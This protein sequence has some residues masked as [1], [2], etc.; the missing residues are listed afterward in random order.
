M[1][2]LLERLG[3]F[4]PA[5][6]ALALPIVFLPS[7]S[8]S[9]ILPRASI[10]ITAACLGSGLAL[11]APAR[12]GLGA[13]KWP[14]L[15]A[16]AAAL[17]AFAFS[18][19]WPLSLAGSYTRY[20]SLPVRLG[21]LGLFASTVWLLRSQKARDLVIPA[22]VLGTAIACLEAI[23]QWAGQV[24]FRPDGNLG[25]A[26]L[27]AALIA[28][29]TPLAVF[30]GLTRSRF[31]VAW[32]AAAVLMVAGL[33]VTTSRSGA[34]GAIAGCLLLIVLAVRGRLAGPALAAS[35]AVLGA[36]VLVILFSPVNEL[37]GDPAALRLNLWR[38]AVRM[39]AARPFTGWGEDTTGLVFGGFLSQNYAAQVTFDRIHSG[40]LDIAATQGLLGLGALGWVVV[41]VLRSAWLHR[42]DRSVGALFA[43]LG[44]YAV[45]VLLN[46][47]WAP[48][49]GLFWLLA[50]TLWSATTVVPP[51][52]VPAPPHRWGG[53]MKPLGAAALV[54]VA[55]LLAVFP[56][57][58]DTWYLRGRAD[59]SVA[60]DPLQARYHWAWG[61]GLVARGELAAGVDELKRAAG[62]GETEPALYVELGDREIEM[63]R[64]TEAVSAYRQA[65]Q[66][67][68]YYEPALQR[69]GSA[70]S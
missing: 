50:G 15:A 47:D 49:A 24:P 16:A 2:Y 35:A 41:T 38:D 26:N 8:D 11:M 52:A 70:G 69:L 63:G 9:Y 58:A 62:L 65:L 64:R 53:V 13:I 44:G 23:Q 33:V 34:L 40:P 1:R 29:G 27:L 68:P 42:S 43:A 59:L 10:V 6:I 30:N 31:M 60:V 12:P 28:M 19:S 7:V 46:F 67:D 48:A 54:L 5:L 57:L 17:L 45:W 36:V 51:P 18:V 20:E 55:T 21:Y 22:F 3:D 37:N 32:W 14:L 66:I 39:I 56:L 61:Q 4:F 25:N